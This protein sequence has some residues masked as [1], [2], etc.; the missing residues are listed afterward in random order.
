MKCQ[1][2]QIDYG[3]MPQ[4]SRTPKY[5]IVLRGINMDVI[6][7]KYG[8]VDKDM[9]KTPLSALDKPATCNTLIFMGASKQLHK[10]NI[11]MIDHRTSNPIDNK[12]NCFWCKNPFPNIPIGCPISCKLASKTTNYTSHINSNNYSIT[13]DV[14]TKPEETVYIT[15]GAFCSFNC[16]MA[17]IEDNRT[18][19]LYRYSKSLL[20]TMYNEMFNTKTTQISPSP[21]WKTLVEYGG[22]LSIDEFREGFDNIEYKDHGTLTMQGISNLFEKK[23]RF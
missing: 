11:S 16:C 9:T 10:C 17:Y 18:D 15:D 4:S 7:D 6:N 14:H 21:H 8:L 12:Y 20:M 19:T 2:L 5:Q 23:L 3:K 22:H 13:E 1:P